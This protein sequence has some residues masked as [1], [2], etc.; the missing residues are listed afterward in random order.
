VL[1]GFDL[2][3]TLFD[4]SNAV[5][6]ALL[7]HEKYH[8]LKSENKEQLKNDMCSL[9]GERAWTEFQGILYCKFV[10]YV[11]ID[12]AAQQVLISL[13]NR[14]HSIAILSHKTHK[15]ILGDDCLLR[16]V[17]S[18]KLQQE[19]RSLKL[20]SESIS[21]TYFDSLFAKIQAIRNSNFD[22]FIDDLREV[23]NHSKEHVGTLIHLDPRSAKTRQ[24]DNVISCRDWLGILEVLKVKHV[25][26]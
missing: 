23:I 5:K 9:F 10:D 21:L 15:P 25:I 19:L 1:I 3:H 11:F 16:D 7:S 4:Y 17:A 14:N 24:K 22:F 26:D 18:K 13:V 12:S 2:D 6:E 20:N 8:S